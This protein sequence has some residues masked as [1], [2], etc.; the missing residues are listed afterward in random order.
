MARQHNRGIK[1][2]EEKVL[3]SYERQNGTKEKKKL[4]TYLNQFKT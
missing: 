2:E 1:V 4:F 3:M